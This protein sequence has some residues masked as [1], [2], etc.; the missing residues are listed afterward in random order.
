MKED[1]L[2]KL[3]TCKV[4]GKRLG[5]SFRDNHTLPLFWKVTLERHML[6]DG[7]LRRQAGLEM[8][9]GHVALAR[10][11]SPDEEMTKVVTGPLTVSVCDHCAMQ[12]VPG[13][14]FSLAEGEEDPAD[15]DDDT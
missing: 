8:M 3:A 11:L 2:R 5:A 9:T 12:S 14:L 10:A 6:D 7:A 1:E 13:G 15:K 4:C